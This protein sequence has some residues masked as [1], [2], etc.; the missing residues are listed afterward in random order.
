MVGKDG[1][2]YVDYGCDHDYKPF[3]R[4]TNEQFDQI[5]AEA[6]KNAE[7]EDF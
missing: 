2:L 6:L 5:R 1:L 3:R 7:T 4:I